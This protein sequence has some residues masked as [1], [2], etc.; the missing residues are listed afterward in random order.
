VKRL[1]T[2][3]MVSTALFAIAL[4]TAIILLVVFV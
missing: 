1:A 2:G 4:A 3:E